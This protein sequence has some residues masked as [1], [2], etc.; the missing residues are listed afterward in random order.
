MAVFQV[1]SG[2]CT[3]RGFADVDADG[4]LAKYKAWVV[5]DAA[6]GGP[7]WHILLDQSANPVAKTFT[8]PDHTN[9]QCYCVDHG[10]YNGDIVYVSNTGGALP[11]GLSATEYYVIKVD[12]DNFRLTSLAS[13]PQYPAF[14]GYTNI[15][16]AG[17]GTQSVIART[18]Y[19]IVS[20]ASAPGVNDAVKILKVSMKTNEAG[21]VRVQFL[22]SFDTVNKIAR[23]YWGGYWLATYDSA[24]FAYDFRGGDECM[25]IQSRLGTSWNCSGIDDWTGDVNFVEAA[26]ATDTLLAAATA[27]SNVVL[28]V[29]DASLFAVGKHYFIYD[30]SGVSSKFVSGSYLYHIDYVKVTARDTDADTVT[31][32][33][34]GIDFP[35]GAV[36]A[37]YAHRFFCFGNSVISGSGIA[38]DNMSYYN[39]FSET[40]LPYYSVDGYQYSSH[41]QNT[42]I[43]GKL[44]SGI[45]Y[46]LLGVM[47]PNDDSQYAMQKF[48]V[49]EYSKSNSNTD[50]TVGCNRAYGVSNNI[51][52]T[53]IGTMAKMM[54]G[55]TL[56]SKNYLYFEPDDLVA[57]GSS[58]YGMCILD[59]ESAS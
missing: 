10:Y 30:Y 45:A 17:S 12:D 59:T 16:S 57:S 47:A 38:Y 43:Y 5:K 9:D 48:S 52:V 6:A 22:L 15:L 51:Y 44:S 29:N 3:G 19:I 34:L 21:Y 49:V 55:R 33:T 37:S 24:S 14:T 39:T 2:S 41:A 31:I 8:V 53:K 20:T 56:G 23:G 35:I 40:Q 11:T 18:T 25:L 36:I 42:V 26:T 1:E 27:G 28:S 13:G 54:D 58:T 7:G 32:Q 50:P 4:F 46:G